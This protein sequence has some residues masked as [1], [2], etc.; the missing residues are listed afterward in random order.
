MSTTIPTANARR[1]RQS[2]AD[3]LRGDF[4]A[5]K[6][7]FK[8]FGVRRTL[9]DVQKQLAAESFGAETSYLSAGKK[10]LT[11][12][13]LLFE[14]SIKCVRVPF[15]IGRDAACLIPSQVFA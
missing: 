11:R 1:A 4:I 6:L 14:Q 15:S 3:Q 8:W 2:P 7:A 10:L 9:S 12:R 5:M 13:I